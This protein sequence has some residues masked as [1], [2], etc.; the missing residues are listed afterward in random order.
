[1]IVSAIVCE[2]ESLIAK[3]SA[4][5]TTQVISAWIRG[6]RVEAE[7]ATGSQGE[8]ISGG[9][10]L[11]GE[12]ILDGERKTGEQREELKKAGHHSTKK[13]T[14]ATSS[15]EISRTEEGMVEMIVEEV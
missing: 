7:R 15:F 2:K 6:G 4:S 8:M 10:M 11:L 13:K 3:V 14:C 9:V 12:M 5:T 1:M